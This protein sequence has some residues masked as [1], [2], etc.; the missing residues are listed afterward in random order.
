MAP[1]TQAPSSPPPQ[2][3]PPVLGAFHDFCLESR[4]TAVVEG[5][6]PPK[7]PPEQ[8]SRL[9]EPLPGSLAL[10]SACLQVPFS[11]PQSSPSWP[12]CRES[13]SRHIAAPHGEHPALGGCLFTLTLCFFGFFFFFLVCLGPHLKHMEVPK[14][15][16]QL[17]LLHH[18]HAG[19]K[20][21]LQPTP[22]LMATPDP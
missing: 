22:Q 3:K 13:L 16:I 15:G 17:E 18:S 2:A 7:V 12:L 19:S 6:I 20:L 21:S 8:S 5:Q 14:L 10:P 4:I 11:P 9:G 1:P